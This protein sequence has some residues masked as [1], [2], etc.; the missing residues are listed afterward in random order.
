MKKS[1]GDRLRERRGARSQAEMASVFGVSQ[2][3]YSAWER[4]VKEPSISTIGSICI[5]FG[6][7]ADWLLGL[8]GASAP[9]V[10]AARP[11]AA[12][13]PD[14]YWRGLVASQQETI[15]NLTRLASALKPSA[16][17]RCGGGG[18]T[19]TA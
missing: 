7:S 6:V 3:A 17:A 4:G 9:T 10:P 15:A 14:S 5:E 13:S 12:S 18:A 19:K 16:P 2:S 8:P 1:F 11:D